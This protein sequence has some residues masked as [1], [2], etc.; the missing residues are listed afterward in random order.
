MP[1]DLPLGNGNLLVNFDHNYELRDIYYPRIGQ[2]NHTSGGP[3]RFGIWVEGRFAW[4]DDPA[5]TRNLVYIADTLVT[6]VTLRHPDLQVSLTFNDAVDL[7]RDA[8]FRRVTVVNDGEAREIRLFFHYD[9]DIY[10]TEVGD[11]VMYYPAVKGLV[12]YKGQRCFAACGQVGDRMGLDGFAC[13]KKD[14]NGAQGTWRDAED[15]EL[16]NNPIEQGSVDMTLCLKLGRVE[17]AQTATAYQWLIAARNFGDLQTVADVI[18]LRGPQA[19]LDRTRSYW[20]AWVNKEDRE[21][22]DLSPRIAELYRRCLLVVRTQVD[23]GGAV[24]A[25]NDSDIVKFARDT[26]SYM[27]PRDAALAVYAMDQAGYVDLPRRFFDLCARIVTKEG[28][29]RHKYTP[30]GDP[31]SSWHPWVDQSGKPQ[32][33]IQEDETGL[34]L[35]SLWQHY[36]RHRDFEFFKAY[37][38]PLI[39]LCA[40]FLASYIDGVTGLPEPSYD[41]WEERRGVM[42][43]T[44][45]AVWA[46][47]QAAANFCQLYGETKNAERYRSVADGIREGARKFLFDP[48]LN[49]F[50]RRIYQRPDGSTARDLTIDSSVYG[51]WYFGMFPADDPQI[52][53]TMKAVYDRLWCKTPV[54]GIAR[55]ENDWYYQV[56][57][58][59]ANVPGNPWFI[60]TMWYAQWVVS[61]AR[62]IDDLQPA[63]NILE[64]V[65]GAALPSGVLAEQ[66]DP[67]TKVTLSVSPLTWSHATVVSLVHE[68]VR[69][70]KALESAP[71]SEQPVAELKMA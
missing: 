63:R 11:T 70:R 46:G 1:R 8:L 45:A 71:T 37:Y 23:A 2:E 49:R 60:C 33:P 16:G 14:V 44:V 65:A 52:V 48:E 24:L 12:A 56:S 66:L 38:R 35:F 57:Q 17:Q 29:F 47:L 30:A 64:W 13:G 61:Q 58:D 25:A 62:S 21:F 40:D 53:S 54:G 27:W 20:T 50:I 15:G 19:F 28:Y 18:A 3:C 22:A 10:G 39:V 67:Y 7:G 9:W 32:Y 43:F 6:D 31:G 51:L 69:K 26:Y 55:Y 42:S 41:L 36:D 68:Y 59:I 4:V 34:V 5:W